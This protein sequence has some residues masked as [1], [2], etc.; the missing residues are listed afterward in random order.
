MRLRLARLLCLLLAATALP[1]IPARAET[2]TILIG[3]SAGGGYDSYGRLLARYFGRHMPGNPTVLAENMAG[4]GSLKLAN[5][6]YAVAP[7]DGSVFGIFTRGMAMEPLLGNSAAKFD[8]RRF[9]WIGSITRETS[10]CVARADTGITRWADLKTHQ[11]VV[12]G[13][14]SGS[15]PDIFARML[16]TELGA[17]IKLVTGF[18]GTGEMNL[19][20]ERNE[21]QGRCGW[22]WSSLKAERADWL[23]DHRLVLL[24]QMGTVSDPELPTVPLITELAETDAQRQVLSLILSRQTLGRPFAAPPSLSPERTATLRAA[25]DATM[26]DPDFLATAKSLGLEVKPVGGA[27]LSDL[28][29]KLY[30]TP[31]PVLAEARTAI[32][33]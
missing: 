7:H 29:A 15:D 12:S 26:A 13:E 33:R 31:V 27:E 28:V 24:A 21:V 32:G 14:G 16:T 20:M 10:L 5:Y 23:A 25:F 11:L 4:A 17:N 9:T 2:I 1:A 19:A 3:Y 30:D 18:P 22:S 6:L 8:S